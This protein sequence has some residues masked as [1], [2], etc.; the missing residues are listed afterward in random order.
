[1]R[2]RPLPCFVM[3]MALLSQNIAAHAQS[4]PRPLKIEP[5]RRDFTLG[6]GIVPPG[7]IQIESG[8]TGSRRGTSRENSYGELTV[9]VPVSERFEVRVEVPS[10]L[11]VRD[12]TGRGSGADDTLL[13]TRLRLSAPPRWAFAITADVRVPTGSRPVAERRWQGG[14]TFAANATLAKCAELLFNLGAMRLS[15]DGEYFDQGTVSMAF[16]Y[17]LSSRFDTFAEIYAMSRMEAGGD[18][19]KFAATGLVYYPVPRVA[20]DARLGTGVS[21]DA[22]S[23]D[24]FGSAGLSVLF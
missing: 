8:V 22:G 14:A 10:F 24:Y 23:P 15:D 13:R 5:D 20:F 16:R 17:E 7:H 3:T 18:S 11:V 9:R 12:D 1:M 4:Q 19:Q 6:T 2:M 21:N